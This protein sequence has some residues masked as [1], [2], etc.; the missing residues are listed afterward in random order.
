MKILFSGYHN[1][2]FMTI[3]E[4]IERAIVKLGHT[5]ISFD[6]RNFIFPGRLRQ[7]APFI[8]KW[9]L[10]RINDKLIA[11]A[12]ENSPDLCLISGGHRIFP[13]TILK[14]K[15]RGILTALWTIDCPLDF[16]PILEAAPFYDFVF[17]GG[18]EA[19]ELLLQSG[20]GD[21]HWLPF[22]CDP[23][24]HKPVNVS[25]EE[26]TKWGSSV[27][28]VGSFYSNRQ[29]VFESISDLDLKIWGPGWNRLP[30][31]SLLRPQ[32]RSAPL[33]LHEWRNIYCSSPIV[34]VVHYR[35]N[36]IPCHQASPKVYE[37]LACKSFLLVDNQKDVQSLFEDKKHLV[38]F[39]DDKDFR[40]LVD[41]YLRHDE[42][43]EQIAL[44]G[45]QEIRQNHSYVHRIKK[46]LATLEQR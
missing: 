41:Y 7:R 20:L 40:S 17:C 31:D 23:D 29:K 18:T 37:T 45:Y 19:Q 5:C 4:Y 33:A 10:N 27:T 25:K 28:F 6:D 1:P 43:R 16:E 38:I 3:T 14:I 46:L 11:A 8:Q 32:A 15:E 42:E 36:Q 35:D 13:G 9:D 34:S 26:R 24:L 22:A 2:H 30:K 12:F 21:T 44:S 39:K